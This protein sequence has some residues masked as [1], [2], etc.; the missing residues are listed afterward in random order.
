MTTHQGS[1]EITPDAIVKRRN[2][3]IMDRVQLDNAAVF[4]PR[5]VYD[6]RKNLFCKR[7]IP[8]GSVRTH[9]LSVAVAQLK[10]LPSIP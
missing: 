1:V 8:S 4:N 6:G 10:F 7:D 9:S 5:A 2:Y 3:E